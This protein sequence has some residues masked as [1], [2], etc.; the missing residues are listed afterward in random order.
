MNNLREPVDFLVPKN[1]RLRLKSIDSMIN[2]ESIYGIKEI[3]AEDPLS[4]AYA[5]NVELEGNIY[6]EI[7]LSE[8]ECDYEKITLYPYKKG[9]ITAYETFVGKSSYTRTVYLKI[10][11]RR[12]LMDYGEGVSIQYVCENLSPWEACPEMLLENEINPVYIKE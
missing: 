3:G 8:F 5:A 12:V 6:P 7:N 1:E 10:V 11:E 2:I 4:E 9:V